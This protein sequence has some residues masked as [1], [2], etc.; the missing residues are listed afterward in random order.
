[1]KNFK[2]I[3]IFLIG[4][5]FGIALFAL[6]SYKSDSISLQLVENP[7]RTFSDGSKLYHADY[8]G[9]DF[10]VVTNPNGG[11]AILKTDI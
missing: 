9:R 11:V 1:M 2:F 4:M 3:G 5:V 6:I 7:I 10:I 8:L